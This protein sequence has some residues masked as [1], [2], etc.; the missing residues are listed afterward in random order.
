MA[1]KLKLL[2]KMRIETVVY[3]PKAVIGEDGSMLLDD[4]AAREVLVRWEDDIIE[5]LNPDGETE[6]SRSLAYVGEDFEISSYLFHGSLAEFVALPSPKISSDMMLEIRGKKKLPT[7]NYGD[8]LRM[9]YL[10]PFN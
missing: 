5:Y 6:Q 3:V 2:K 7:I 1:R 8:Y 9:V 10:G 4:A